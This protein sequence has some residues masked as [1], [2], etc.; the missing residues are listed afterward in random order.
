MFGNHGSNHCKSKGSLSSPF[1]FFG[2][3]LTLLAGLI[4]S[5]LAYGQ[6]DTIFIDPE[7]PGQL[8]RTQVPFRSEVLLK[9]QDLPQTSAAH[10]AVFLDNQKFTFISTSPDRQSLAFCVDAQLHDWTGTMNLV[11]HQ[12]KQL[13]LSFESEAVNPNFSEDGRFLTLEEIQSQGRHSLEVFNL[14]KDTECKLDGRDARDK[15]YNFSDSWWSPEG[16][17]LYFKVEYNN[18][19]RKS[20]GLRSKSIPIR[21]G[22][23]TP[24]CEKIRY[25]SIADFMQKHPGQLPNSD[26]ALKKEKAD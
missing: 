8:I 21:I 12:I 11:D 4:H 5:P 7:N 16:D 6:V 15:F 22:E 13:G 1:F 26:L 24:E 19:Y 18:R 2:V 25:Y 23:A 10:P 14:E 17:R 3:G 9:I 20:L